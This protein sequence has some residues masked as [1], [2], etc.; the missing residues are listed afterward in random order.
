MEEH[1]EWAN[2]TIQYLSMNDDEET[3]TDRDERVLYKDDLDQ[4]IWGSPGTQESW[5]DDTLQ[6]VSCVEY[7]TQVLGDE[8]PETPR[9]P[10][11][12]RS[13]VL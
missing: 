10:G 9:S 11:G 4:K 1:Q 8:K 6:Y 5:A 2:Q 12:H 7:G 13:Q 3:K